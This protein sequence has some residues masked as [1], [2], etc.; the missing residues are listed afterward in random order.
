MVV[1]V[2]VVDDEVEVAAVDIAGLAPLVVLAVD[3]AA[4]DDIAA[5]ADIAADPT[6]SSMAD[7]AAAAVASRFLLAYVQAMDLAVEVAC[8]WQY[9]SPQEALADQEDTDHRYQQNQYQH[10]HSLH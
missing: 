4:A 9:Y 7:L 1:D 3:I 8:A 5:A 10:K 6:P 2:L